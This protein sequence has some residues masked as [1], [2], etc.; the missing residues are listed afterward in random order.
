MAYCTTD[1]L[2]EAMFGK[3]NFEDWKGIPENAKRK[4][5]NM[6]EYMQ[7]RLA[8][9]GLEFDANDLR[10]FLAEGVNPK[11]QEKLNNPRGDMDVMM[12]AAA[13]N[14]KLVAAMGGRQKGHILG[15]EAIQAAHGFFM[16]R[17]NKLADDG[18]M[19]ADLIRNGN[20]KAMNEAVQHLNELMAIGAQMTGNASELGRA[21]R[22][23]KNIKEAEKTQ[24]K[25]AQLFGTF[26]C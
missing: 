16:D 18:V 5:Y 24:Q 26:E 25:F 8:E 11:R 21:L 15:P 1:E 9:R 3:F 14:E 20:D 13:F 22:W 7:K 17:A 12:A 23:M 19:L 2:A 4:L 10:H 6:P